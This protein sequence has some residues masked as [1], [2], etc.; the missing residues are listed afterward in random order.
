MFYRNIFLANIFLIASFGY[1][2]AVATVGASHNR[3]DAVGRNR[4]NVIYAGT[5]MMATPKVTDIPVETEITESET[6]TEPTPIIEPDPEPD[7]TAD[8][9]AA[10]EYIERL[11]NEIA[12]I[13]SEIA[14]CKKTKKT[15]AIGT[16][17]GGVG[18][19]G[20]AAGAIVQAV[21]INKAKKNGA[22][23]SATDNDTK[24]SE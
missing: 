1:A 10:S 20:T 3:V 19:A 24:E 22:T 12:Q 6:V 2:G 5:P 17:V 21:Q 15:W 16:V 14:R 23:E 8:I 18:V 13:D 11:K 4:A 9:T 7:L